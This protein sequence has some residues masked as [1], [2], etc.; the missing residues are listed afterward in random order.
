MQIQ[1]NFA[2]VDQSDALERHVEEQLEGAIGRFADR[3]TRVEVHISDENSPSKHG[4]ADKRCL[5]EARPAGLKPVTV[6]E[7]S[8]DLYAAVKGAVGK[9]ERVLEKRLE[10]D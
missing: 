9:L 6:E 8:D 3:L 1:Y 4:S 5:L 2:N 10:K 7:R